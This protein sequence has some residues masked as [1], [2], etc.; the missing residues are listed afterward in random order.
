MSAQFGK[1]NF[2]DRPLDRGELEA[3]ESLIARY[4]S[5]ER[6][7]YSDDNISICCC[8]FPTTQEARTEKQPCVTA[9]GAVITWDGRL[10]NRE[11]LI[12]RLGG[13]LGRNASDADIVSSA[14]QEWDRQCL[15]QLIG[16][17]A[18]SVWDPVTQSLLLAQDPIGTHHLYYLLTRTGVTWS[19]VLD[20]LVLLSERRLSLS[21]EYVAGWLTFFPSAQLTPYAEIR[22]VPSACSIC[23]TP[24]ACSIRRYWEFDRG[25]QIRYGKDAEYEEHF[26]DVFFRAVRRRLRSNRPILAELSGG[27]DSGSIVS[28]A[29]TIARSSREITLD[30]LS[31]YDNSEPHWNESPYFHLVEKGRGRPGLHIDLQA[32]D[33]VFPEYIPGHAALTPTS[34]IRPSNSIR[35]FREHVQQ[36][37]YRVVLSGIGGDEVT[38]GVPTPLSELADHLVRAELKTFVRQLQLWALNRREPLL[39][40]I[41]DAARNFLPSACLSRKGMQPAEWFNR[42][43]VRAYGIPLLGYPARTKIFGS[44]PSFQ[45]AVTALAGV[46]RQLACECA[47][48]E[49]LFEKR[50]PF[51]D[52]EFL[53]FMFAVPREQLLRPGQRRSL[54]RRALVGIVPD[55]VLNRK[56]KAFVSRAFT[57][58]VQAHWSHLSQVTESL[59]LASMGIVDQK[60]FR[61]SLER[62]HST[63]QPPT[64]SM[65]RAIG[66]EYWLRH[67]QRLRTLE[68]PELDRVRA[69]PGATLPAVS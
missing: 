61:H 63:E 33:S 22:S 53:E 23:I 29:D 16:D 62:V 4:G 59:L 3:A 14:Y 20:P 6:G 57:I 35:Q 54:M 52:R 25:K 44:L 13:S 32:D 10:D 28:V 60:R 2:G 67:Q 56:R 49:T 58:A 11:E 47:S 51:L 30:T 31:Y 34:G 19:T 42:E 50:Y 7:R 26:R 65:I 64:L 21:L 15:P 40:L 1:W 66:I 8:A 17:W 5:G 46:Q 37:D 41:L 18:L 38:G 9:R 27:I 68:L 39:C 55:R 45:D 43:F 12:E 36:N 24:K 69:A 48:P